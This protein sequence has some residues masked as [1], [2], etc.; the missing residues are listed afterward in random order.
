M[1]TMDLRRK[2]NGRW[3]VSSRKGARRRSRTFDRNG[4]PQ[5]YMAWLRRRQQLGQAAVPDDVPLHEFVETNWR[6]HAL[7]NLPGD[8]RPLQP[9]LVTPSHPACVTR[10]STAFNGDARSGT[11]ASTMRVRCNRGAQSRS[12]SARK[13][14]GRPAPDTPIEIQA[15]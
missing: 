14:Q 2:P 9:R 1:N 8:S 10:S 3:E 4:D 11:V 12:R 13:P 15:T 7:P 5:N 6:L